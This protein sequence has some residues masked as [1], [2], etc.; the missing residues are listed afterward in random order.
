MQLSLIT[1]IFLFLSLCSILQAQEKIVLG[2]PDG[3]IAETS[4]EILLYAYDQIGLPIEIVS[5]PDERSLL[6]SNSGHIDGEVLRIAAVSEM[7]PNL[8]RIPV[9]I[10]K[11]EAM[12]FTK[13]KDVVIQGWDSLRPYSISL[14]IGTKFAERGTKG[15]NVRALPSNKEVF[16]VLHRGR[17]D[18]AVASRLTG[19]Y[20]IKRLGLTDIKA[21]EPTLAN[22]NLY[23]Y[24]NKKHESIIPKIT[25][26]LKKMEKNGMIEKIRKEYIEKIL[27]R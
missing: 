1:T 27:T 2:A 20:E 3:T 24:L 10:D 17:F 8:V 11:F 7:Y 5:L 19:M 12:A 13:R 15:M 21:V 4:T 25:L 22:Y 18:I 6:W 16:D 26:E 9:I 14:R 23:H